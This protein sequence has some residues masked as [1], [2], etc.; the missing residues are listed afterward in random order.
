MEW[1]FANQ[2]GA[3]LNHN[4]PISGSAMVCSY[5]AANSSAFGGG[6]LPFLLRNNQRCPEN[7]LQRSWARS[8]NRGALFGGAC[9]L[10]HAWK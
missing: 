9:S 8:K 10:R 7:P 2:Q 5:Y 6:C 3:A 4:S 1:W